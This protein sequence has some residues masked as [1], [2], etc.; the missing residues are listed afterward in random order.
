MGGGADSSAE[1]RYSKGTMEVEGVGP[2][3]DFHICLGKASRVLN[4]LP[5]ALVHA[6]PIFQIETDT[7]IDQ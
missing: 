3:D 6:S 7:R 5:L 2:Q 4:R 1:V